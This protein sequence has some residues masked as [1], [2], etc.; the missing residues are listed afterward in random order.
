MFALSFSFEDFPLLDSGTQCPSVL[1][2]HAHKYSAGAR[3]EGG[4]TQN[5]CTVVH[6]HLNNH[7]R[8]EAGAR[9]TREHQASSNGTRRHHGPGPRR[10]AWAGRERRQVEVPRPTVGSQQVDAAVGLIRHDAHVPKLL[11]LGGLQLVGLR[12]GAC[13]P[14]VLEPALGGKEDGRE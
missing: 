9:H 3:E 8:S 4:Q 7:G 2:E 11:G 13:E 14:G 10:R 6:A 5:L 1:L 12:G